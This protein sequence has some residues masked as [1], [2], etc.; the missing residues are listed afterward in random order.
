MNGKEF[1]LEV[2]VG[3]IGRKDTEGLVLTRPE[4]AVGFIQALNENDVHPHVDCH[5]KR[6]LP[7]P[8]V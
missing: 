7:R 8:C 3:E 6:E 5:R 4:E 1:G 2:E